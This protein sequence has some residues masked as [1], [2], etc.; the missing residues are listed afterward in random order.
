MQADW[1]AAM[2]SMK[3][4]VN[5]IAA[6]LS[7]APNA[8]M[9]VE[10][11]RL[12]AR[13]RPSWGGAAG[14]GKQDGW[15]SGVPAQGAGGCTRW[16][17]WA[18]GGGKQEGGA[19]ASQPKGDTTSPAPSGGGHLA[20]GSKK[21]GAAAS[22]PKGQSAGGATNTAAPGGGGRAVEEDKMGVAA[23]TKPAAAA[24]T[25]AVAA[26]KPCWQLPVGSKFAASPA[27]GRGGKKGGTAVPRLQGELAS[28]AG[29]SR[30]PCSKTNPDHSFPKYRRV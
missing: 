19:A 13:Q 7:V 4:R 26:S 30:A 18:A 2:A 21:G 25:P 20:A 24:S 9:V 28:G 16:W 29:T 11:V 15:R 3:A 17:W 23:A 22:R 1:N 12:G 6:V 10:G 5:N 27:Q 14:G 8:V